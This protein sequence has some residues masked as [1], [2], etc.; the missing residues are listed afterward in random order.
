[1]VYSFDQDEI[2]EAISANLSDDYTTQNPLDTDG[3]EDFFSKKG[4]IEV[5][6]LLAE[7]PKPFQRINDML[8][9]SRTTVS[10]RLSEGVSH[11]LWG[12]EIIYFDN[13]K[14]IKLYRL[15]TEATDIADIVREKNAYETYMKYFRAKSD[16]EEEIS[17]IKREII[18]KSD[19]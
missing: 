2:E 15:D 13:D 10:K 7:N 11:G 3:L 17:N 8:P 14:R 6:I 1:M 9:V 16:Y 4:A 12:E 5:L 19:E 18:Q